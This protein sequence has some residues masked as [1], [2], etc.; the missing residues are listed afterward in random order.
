MFCYSTCDGAVSTFPLCPPIQC[1]RVQSY[2]GFAQHGTHSTCQR[3]QVH[4]HDRCYCVGADVT[5]VVMHQDIA[6][7][8]DFT[9]GNIRLLGLPM[10]QAVVAWLRTRFKGCAKLRR[11]APDPGSGGLV[12]Y[13][14]D[15]LDGIGN[16][17]GV[18]LPGFV[19][20]S[21]ASR[22]T[23]WRIWRFN[24]CSG[25]T[26]TGRLSNW[27]SWSVKGRRWANRS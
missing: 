15:A 10:C 19:H 22:K 27:A 5:Q 8:A 12:P 3:I 18:R 26:S 21:T 7:P 14:P 6:K 23:C 20:D 24:S 13:L 11:T 4:F 25:I 9:P 17:Q 1:C 16:M 2:S